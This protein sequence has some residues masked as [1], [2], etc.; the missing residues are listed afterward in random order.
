MKQRLSIII[1]TLFTSLIIGEELQAQPYLLGFNSREEILKEVAEDV[2]LDELYKRVLRDADK[3]LYEPNPTVVDKGVTPP[4]GD[5]HDYISM[6]R[7]WWPN[8][9]TE[10]GLPYVRRD[11]ESNPE[12]KQ[13]DRERLGGF[14]SMLRTLSYGYLLSENPD[15]ARKIVSMLKTWFLSKKSLMNPNMTYAQMVPGRNGGLGRAE[16]LLDTYSLLAA[17]DAAVIVEREGY[18]SKK[19]ATALRQWF[20]N[21]VEWMQTSDSGREEFE[22][23]NNHGVAYDVQLAVFAHYA[24]LEDVSRAIV[25]GFA[26]RRL[27]PQIEADGSQPFELRR[28]TAFGYSTF[29]LTHLL[30]MCMVARALNIDLYC[31]ADS[32]IDRAI[33]FLIP[34]MGNRANFPYKQIKD[35]QKV[36]QDLAEQLLRASRLCGNEDYRSLYERFRTPQESKRAAFI[37]FNE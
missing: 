17:V 15:Y 1:F 26:Q 21:Y 32:A 4:S 29:N 16:G 13:F 23:K 24:G 11:G 20:S 18:L 8:P 34:F 19:D 25:E 30:D 22:A 31:A 27:E 33:G 28:T 7:Y 6:G 12:L 2:R 14:A 3:V 9:D 35:W 5:K 10:D 36:E 37:L